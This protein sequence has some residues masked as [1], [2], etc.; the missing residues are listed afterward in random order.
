MK[1]RKL[2]DSKYIQLT[3]YPIPSIIALPTKNE[4]H[5]IIINSFY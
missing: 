2:M 5:M 3:D 1:S 4:L